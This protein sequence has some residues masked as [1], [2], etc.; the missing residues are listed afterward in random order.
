M[1][2]ESINDLIK[3]FRLKRA[4]ELLLTDRLT[5]SETAYNTGFS[6]PAYFSKVFKE[7]YKV[8]PKDFA[9]TP[10]LQTLN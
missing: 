1:S 4:G 8:S 9:S 6:D 3:Y 10:N 5:V 7:H 2:T